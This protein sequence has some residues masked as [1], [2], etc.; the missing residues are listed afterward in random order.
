MKAASN[1]VGP[2]IKR[3][4]LNQVLP[5]T[6]LA[7]RCARLGWKVSVQTLA[8]IEFRKRSLADFEVFIL[9]K[10]LEVSPNEFDAGK[11]SLFKRSR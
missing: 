11:V 1:L 9:A 10:A 7:R 4:R 8:R 6:E 2:A 5:R 3:V